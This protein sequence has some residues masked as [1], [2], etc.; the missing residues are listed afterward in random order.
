MSLICDKCRC[1]TQTLYPIDYDSGKGKLVCKD[2]FDAHHKSKTNKIDKDELK[3]EKPDIHKI[4]I[5]KIGFN[6]EIKK[7]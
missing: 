7:E 4:N 2:C 5:P 6:G 1:K 3:I